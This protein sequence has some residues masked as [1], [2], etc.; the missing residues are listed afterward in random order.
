MVETQQAGC[1]WGFGST[2]MLFLIILILVLF[3]GWPFVGYG[4]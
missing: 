1:G 2:G 3:P 4:N